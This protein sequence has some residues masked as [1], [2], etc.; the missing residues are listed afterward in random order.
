MRR[1][2]TL[3]KSDRRLAMRGPFISPNLV[4]WLDAGRGGSGT[5]FPD[6][7]G[8][9]TATI[10]SS[11][12]WAYD[13]PGNVISF[14]GSSQ[15]MEVPHAAS[16]N[17]N[18]DLTIAIYIKFVAF[19]TAGKYPNLIG[20]NSDL[21]GYCLFFNGD[22]GTVN[23]QT[24]DTGAWRVVGEAV[25]GNVSTG[26]W[27]HYCGVVGGSGSA[28]KILYRNGKRVASTS[29]GIAPATNTQPVTIAKHYST[30]GTYGYLNC[31]IASAGIWNRAFTEG[32]VRNLYNLMRAQSA[33]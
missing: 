13:K 12:Q 8:A 10:T 5:T 21:T 27:V 9:H 3:A 15:I 30:P 28:D 6:R 4:L 18:G 29:A 23:I 14:N 22:T 7:T 16:L 32:E 11:L 17:I 2:M 1:G 24:G 25:S 33:A 31:R 19:P 26:E 20:K